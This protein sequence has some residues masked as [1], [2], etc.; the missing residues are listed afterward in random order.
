MKKEYH[1]PFNRIP[2]SETE[3]QVYIEVEKQQTK[4]RERYKVAMSYLQDPNPVRWVEEAIEE[5]VDMLQ[6]LVSMKMCLQSKKKG[7]KNESNPGQS[8]YE[9][10]R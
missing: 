4:G 6:Y 5:C 2:L 9:S 1:N 7:K 3:R 8:Q 10:N